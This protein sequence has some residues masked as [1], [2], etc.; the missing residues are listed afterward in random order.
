[1]YSSLIVI[2]FPMEFVIMSI[3]LN[4]FYQF[5]LHTEFITAIPIL[6]KIFVMP[7]HHKVHH[8]SN[9]EYLDRNYGGVFIIWDKI[10][11]TYAPLKK[12]PDYGLTTPIPHK[13]FMNIQLFYYKKLVENFRVFGFRRGVQL[14]FLGP[15]H[16]TPDIPTSIPI[17]PKITL[18]KVIVGILIYVVSYL[19]LIRSTEFF[20]MVMICAVNFLAILIVNGISIELI[21]PRTMRLI[22][23]L[24]LNYGQVK[25]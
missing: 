22:Q 21:I 13:D 25:K 23:K 6:E 1:M 10:F 9:S 19:M 2:G 18:S 12:K 3:Y 20:T 4:A 11:K 17:K 16:Q 24:F 14:L 15:E 7:D 8:G 5:Y